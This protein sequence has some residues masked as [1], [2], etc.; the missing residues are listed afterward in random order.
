MSGLYYSCLVCFGNPNSSMT[1]GAIAGV[2]S[3]FVVV[4]FVLMGIAATGFVW[5]ARAKKMQGEEAC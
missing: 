3:L 4:L 2:L 1:K 5:A